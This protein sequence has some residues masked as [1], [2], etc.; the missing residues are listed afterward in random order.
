MQ[1]P[2]HRPRPS[3]PAGLTRLM[4]ATPYMQEK[5]NAHFI[6]VRDTIAGTAVTVCNIYTSHQYA[7]R[8]AFFTSLYD[9]EFVHGD[10]VI[11]GGDYSCTLDDLADRSNHGSTS[12][13]DPPDLRILLSRWGALDPVAIARSKSWDP[14]T[15]RRHHED[16][17]PPPHTPTGY[18][19]QASLHLD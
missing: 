14:E 2:L 3:G 10:L 5:W 12:D 13:P 6:A 8:E 1:P 17:P 7:A 4:P 16:P 19:I 9:I 18:Q 11:I 15:L